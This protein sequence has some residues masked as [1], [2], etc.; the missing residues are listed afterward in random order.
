MVPG[1]VTLQMRSAEA[2]DRLQFVTGAKLQLRNE[3]VA[4]GDGQPAPLAVELL[5]Q[6]GKDSVP[7]RLFFA[8]VWLLGPL[9][10]TRNRTP[11][12]AD[13][14][15]DDL[16]ALVGLVSP[17]AATRRRLRQALDRLEALGVVA[18]APGRGLVQV[19]LRSDVGMKVGQPAY[20]RPGLSSGT[21]ADA[22]FR[23]PAELATEGFL[24]LLSGRALV[25]L[26][27]LQFLAQTRR[28][29]MTQGLFISESMREAR[30]CFGRRTYYQGAAELEKYRIISRYSEKLASDSQMVRLA[31]RSNVDQPGLWFGPELVDD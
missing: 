20:V 10:E 14:N 7:T 4:K 24:A 30:F 11:Y 26:S 22:Y 5:R 25:V 21:R 8:L 31:I 6:G 15:L 19:R 28:P 13:V 16:A 12:A 29:D 1:L 3:F 9:T 2:A 17:Q 18:L 27:A 23:L